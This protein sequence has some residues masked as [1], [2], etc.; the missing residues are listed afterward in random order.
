LKFEKQKIE[1]TE[2]TTFEIKN[3]FFSLKW[4]N[5]TQDCLSNS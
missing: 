4:G 2:K 1:E 3:P 5:K